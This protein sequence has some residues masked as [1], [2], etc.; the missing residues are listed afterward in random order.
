M[1][2]AHG[3]VA[4]LRVPTSALEAIQKRCH[5]RVL[6]DIAVGSGWKSCNRWMRP[7]RD[8]PLFWSKSVQG[9][10]SLFSG[11]GVVSDFFCL[12]T[13]KFSAHAECVR[14]LEIQS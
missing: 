1:C 13:G 6:V 3:T 5:V 8:M 7:V 14:G 4:E 9:L 11:V 10:G 2:S 12:W